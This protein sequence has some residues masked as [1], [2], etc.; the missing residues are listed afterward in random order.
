MVH[1]TTGRLWKG[2]SVPKVPFYTWMSECE[3]I[4]SIHSFRN[5]KLDFMVDFSI[6]TL[7]ELVLYKCIFDY[8]FYCRVAFNLI[9]LPS[10]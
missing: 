4:Q 5:S 9:R 1:A 2:Q 3:E 7:K 6:S 10:S 8:H